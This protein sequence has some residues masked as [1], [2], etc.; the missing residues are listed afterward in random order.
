[1]TEEH[2]QMIEDCLKR[3]TKLTAWEI[4]FL[5]D[6]EDRK[7]L[8]PKQIEKLETIWERVTA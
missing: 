8:S 3:D 4:D 5:S 1:M 7:A 2:K 6:I